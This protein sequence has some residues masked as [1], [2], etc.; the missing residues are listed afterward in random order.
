MK[1]LYLLSM[2]LG[3]S[4]FAF[5]Q[6]TS[7]TSGVLN[8][9][10]SVYFI[11]E[12]TGWAC[13]EIAG[14]NAPILKTIDGGN[15]WTLISHPTLYALR[16][17]HFIDEDTGII[18][19]FH[20]T[21]LRT[22]NGGNTWDSI[23]WGATN[24][25]RSVYFPSHDTG[26]ACGGGGTILKTTDAGLTWTPQVSG[27]TQ[28]LINIR[29][30]SNDLG[31]AV[32]STS[33]FINGIVIKTTDGGATWDSVY[34]NSQGLLGLA[35]V[36][37]STVYAGGGNT[38]LSGPGY[39]AYIVKSADGG[40]S[41][42]TVFTGITMET[43]RGADFISVD[44]GWF[45]GDAGY[46]LG[47]TDGGAT[48]TEDSLVT[49]DL[50]GIHFP[51]SHNGYAVGILG[52]IFKY[53]AP[54]PA[55]TPIDTINGLSFEIC[56]NDTLLYGV[57]SIAGAINY[58]FEVPDS[59]TIVGGNGGTIILVAFTDQ[60]G[61]ISVTVSSECDTVYRQDFITVHP[62]SVPAIT[63]DGILLT[64][65]L[66]TTYQWRI[67]GSLIGGATNQSYTP[68]VN[69]I[70][71]VDVTNEWGCEATSLPYNL[72]AVGVD[73]LNENAKLEIFPNPVLMTA[74]I[75]VYGNSSQHDLTIS[76]VQGKILCQMTVHQ[77]QKIIIDRKDFVEG[78]Y[79][80]SLLNENHKLIVRCKLVVQ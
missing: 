23:P 29:F 71:T 30:A 57:D 6:W 9:L 39:F 32:S 2:L 5:A 44:T 43:L 4:T 24:D 62:A 68:V 31:Y 64:S 45:V 76:N 26:Y 28:D 14:N 10:R 42:D 16:G 60:S 79:F 59:A 34:F 7:L 47:T 78:M 12:D 53:T 66:A 50:L 21:I 36:D 35:V 38:D 75:I 33:A 11:N 15:T 1:K 54:C 61:Y 67:S 52:T 37:D 22:T 56:P 25:L 41:W 48:W 63:F 74:T 18:V 20:G 55:L 13:G 17:I 72:I 49:Q 8:S 51:D 46:L 40:T 58:L 77:N 27:Q 73:E 3:C 19:G 80:I 65:S 70:Y 69:G